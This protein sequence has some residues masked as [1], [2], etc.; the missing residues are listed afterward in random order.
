M[1]YYAYMTFAIVA[2]AIWSDSEVLSQGK[3]P[4]NIPM[5][6]ESKSDFENGD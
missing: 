5:V 1:H 3:V 4:I 6:L 2:L